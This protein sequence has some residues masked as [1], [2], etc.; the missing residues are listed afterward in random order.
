MHSGWPHS[1]TGREG[2]HLMAIFEDDMNKETVRRKTF[3]YRDSGLTSLLLAAACVHQHSDQVVYACQDTD[4][5][6]HSND[7]SNACN[8]PYT[9]DCSSDVGDQDDDADPS[10]GLLV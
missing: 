4:C 2:D 8:N 10:E 1:K 7:N 6:T 3:V 9:S 5:D